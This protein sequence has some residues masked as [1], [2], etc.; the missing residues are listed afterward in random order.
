M[1]IFTL[2]L[3]LSSIL[4]KGLR[5]SHCRCRSNVHWAFDD[6]Q[7][8]YVHEAICLLVIMIWLILSLVTKCKRKRTMGIEVEPTRK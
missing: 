3:L 5:D 8:V 2:S 4:D 6:M 1:E 7:V